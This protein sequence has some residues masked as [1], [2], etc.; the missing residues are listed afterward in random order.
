MSESRQKPITFWYRNYKGEE[1]YRRV[2]PISIRF[3]VSDWHKEPQWLML[4]DDLGPS[5]AAAT[6]KRREFAMRDI[7]HVVNAEPI[8]LSAEL[9]RL[10]QSEAALREQEKKTLQDLS[11]WCDSERALLG[12]VDGYDYRSGE[13]FGIRRVEIQIEKRLAA[14]ASQSA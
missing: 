9:T 2:R 11:A 8:G 13:E 7:R 4:A 12:G 14:L 5:D 1:G 6:I 3:G 10:R